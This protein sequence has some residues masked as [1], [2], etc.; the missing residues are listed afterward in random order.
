MTLSSFLMKVEKNFAHSVLPAPGSPMKTMLRWAFTQSFKREMTSDEAYPVF[1]IVSSSILVFGSDLLM[2]KAMPPW[3]TEGW[4]TV[5]RSVSVSAS[6]TGASLYFTWGGF[7]LLQ[8]FD[9][10][11]NRIWE[12]NIFGKSLYDIA[13]E[14]LTAKLTRMPPNIRN[15]LRHTMQRLVNDGGYGLLCIIF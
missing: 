8:G 11:I 9:G 6:S 13:E 12:S 15:R 10:D 1:S 14:G 2:D 5:I 4:T 7:T 3:D